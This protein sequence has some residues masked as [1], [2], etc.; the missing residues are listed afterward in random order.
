M[1][2]CEQNLDRFEHFSFILDSLIVICYDICLT[3]C[4]EHYYFPISVLEFI[5]IYICCMCK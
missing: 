1:I 3:H 4:N 5:I 2:P